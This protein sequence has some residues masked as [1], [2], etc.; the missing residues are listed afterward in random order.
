M[1]LYRRRRRRGKRLVRVE[2]DAKKVEALV[3][4]RYLDPENREDLGVIE[5]A[6]NALVSDLLD[7]CHGVTVTIPASL[8][9]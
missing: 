6:V 8:T 4:L 7:P 3:R 9:S 1:R 5:F 2:I